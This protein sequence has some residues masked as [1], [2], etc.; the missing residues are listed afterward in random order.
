M[1]LYDVPSVSVAVRQ[2]GTEP[3][4]HAYGVATSGAADTVSPRSIFQACSISKHVA[5]FGALRLVDQGVL[6]LDEDIEKYLTSWRLPESDDWRVVV[7][8]RQLLA[9]TAGLSY[10]W[11]RGF[12]RGDA[13][14]T[15]T[16]V[17]RGQRPATSPPVRA[18]MLPGSGF[19]YSGSH[20]AVLEQVMEDVTGSEFAELMR[21]LVLEPLGMADSSYDQ[22]FPRRY[23]QVAHGHYL[24]GTPLPGG[25]RVQPELAGAGLWT[26]P[27]D[28]T[29]VGA[30]VA[31]A[32]AGRSALLSRD[33]ATEMITPQV[34]GGFGLGTSVGDDGRLRFGHTGGNAGYGCWLFT[35]P[36]TATSMA[37][38]VNNDMANEV[39]LAVLAAAE[40][41]Y[42][43]GGS[44]P[45]RAPVDVTGTYRVRDDY[46][47]KITGEGDELTLHVPGQAPLGLRALPNGRYRAIALDCELAFAPRD[48]E[49][50]LQVRQQDMTLTAT[51]Q[52]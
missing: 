2:D 19:R 51:R 25:W 16:E 38:M 27:S 48:G 24:D 21:S 34:P 30:E 15:S 23:G 43:G 17:L 39:L 14:P 33:L 26:T 11:F 37:V 49:V 47:V 10:N 52:P 41:H 1:G 12:S 50:V 22:D 6:D 3:W 5:A 13:T 42:G 20:Y 7:T 18:T 8:V 45:H 28:L 40:H 29:R 44:A 46:I 35:W 31:H 4:A 9:H 32:V 36:A